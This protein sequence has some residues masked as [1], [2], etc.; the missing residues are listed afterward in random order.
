ML[1]YHQDTRWNIQLITKIETTYT[2]PLCACV[3]EE[4]G[5]DGL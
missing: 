2:Y 4:G 3:E 5:E 1:I